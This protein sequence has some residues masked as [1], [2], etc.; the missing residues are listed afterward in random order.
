MELQEFQNEVMK[1]RGKKKM[2]VSNSWGVY[3]AYKH[4][5]KHRWYDIGRPLKEKEFYSIIRKI[6]NLLAEEVKNGREISF[7]CRMGKLE[8]RK[9]K[10]GV[11]LV[12]GKLRNT[13]PVNWEE[14]VKLWYEDKE[15]KERKLLVRNEVDTIYRVRYCKYDA[16]F[17]NKCFYEFSLNRF[18]KIALKDN[19]NKGKIDTLW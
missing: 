6:N 14:T 7:P 13:Y 8:L 18:I 17:E 11:S 2:K 1:K 16:T 3:D 5:R 15:A 10:R 12:D 4:I 19:I 9:L